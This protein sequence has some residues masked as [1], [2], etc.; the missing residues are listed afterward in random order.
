[1]SREVES[2]DR[3]RPA[4]VRLGQCAR[5]AL[6]ETVQEQQHGAVVGFL[7]LLRAGATLVIDLIAVEPRVRGRGIASDLVALAERSTENVETLRVGTQI[8]NVPSIRLYETLGFRTTGATY[9]FHY[10]SP[11]RDAKRG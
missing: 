8:A 10:H 2:E 5:C 3:A 1:M 7:Q 4:L 6:A 11:A 9:V